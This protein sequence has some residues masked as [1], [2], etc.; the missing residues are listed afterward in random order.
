MYHRSQLHPPL[1]ALRTYFSTQQNT[2]VQLQRYD[3]YDDK[4]LVTRCNFSC[5]LSRDDDLCGVA[6]ARWGVL[7]AATRLCFSIKASR[8]LQ[9]AC[10]RSRC[11]GNIARQVAERVLHDATLKKIGA[12]VAESRTRFYFVQR[13]MQLVSQR[14]WPLHSML[15][16]AMVRAT[17]LA[18]PLRDKLHGKLHR[19][20]GP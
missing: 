1:Y 4:G 3:N 10:V 7:H 20:T 12:I 5:N 2:R 19:V 16:G 18:T 9:R 17:C 14:F 15:H 11:Y 6:V 8:L 13:L